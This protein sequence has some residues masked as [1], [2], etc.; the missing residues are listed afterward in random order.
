MSDERPHPQQVVKFA[1]YKADR[2][3]RAQPVEERSAAR[4]ELSEMLL[5]WKERVPMLRINT[6]LGFRPA[7]IDALARAGVVRLDET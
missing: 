2:A 3:F 6:E 1:F 5:E 4:K 7:D